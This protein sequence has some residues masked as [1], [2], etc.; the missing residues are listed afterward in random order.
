MPVDVVFNHPNMIRNEVAHLLE[1]MK[2][3][4]GEQCR[5]VCN[6]LAAS[7]NPDFRGYVYQIDFDRIA[8]ECVRILRKSLAEGPTPELHTMIDFQ[9]VKQ[10]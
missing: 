8:E 6:S 7:A 10:F 1:E 4:V 2:I 9:I 3:D 5:L